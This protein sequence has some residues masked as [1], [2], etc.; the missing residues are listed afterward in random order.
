MQHRPLVLAVLLMGCGRALAGDN[1]EARN[2]VVWTGKLSPELELTC[3]LTY[4]S[5]NRTHE[6]YGGGQAIRV[7][8]EQVQRCI[9]KFTKDG[10]FRLQF[11]TFRVSWTRNRLRLKVAQFHVKRGNC[12]WAVFEFRSD[13]SAAAS[14]VQRLKKVI[15]KQIN[16]GAQCR[17]LPELE[18]NSVSGTLR[19]RPIMALPTYDGET[20]IEADI[21]LSP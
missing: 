14:Y 18:T 17:L 2:L 12:G 13:V 19:D 21:E 20:K 16:A 9:P 15:I 3:N 8:N 10:H 11:G 4:E 7:A 6:G 1:P 5:L